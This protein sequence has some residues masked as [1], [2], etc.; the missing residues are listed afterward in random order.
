MKKN[1]L[2]TQLK[3]V[4]GDTALLRLIEVKKKEGHWVFLRNAVS[5]FCYAEAV[6]KAHRIMGILEQMEEQQHDIR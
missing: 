2:K 4:C 5:D 3:N 1:N 6:D